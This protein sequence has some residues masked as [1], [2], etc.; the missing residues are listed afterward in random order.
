M[1]PS[2]Q[3]NDRILVNKLAY[4]LSSP[5]RGSIVVFKS[6]PKTIEG[7]IEN[8]MIIFPDRRLDKQ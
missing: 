6:P 1:I 7:R 2:L 3:E 8:G 4:R 5:K